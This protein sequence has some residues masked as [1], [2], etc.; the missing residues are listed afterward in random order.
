MLTNGGDNENDDKC[1]EDGQHGGSYCIYEC[2]EAPQPTEEPQDPES[3][4][5]LPFPLTP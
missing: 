1:V 2:P 3:S 5:R 4:Q